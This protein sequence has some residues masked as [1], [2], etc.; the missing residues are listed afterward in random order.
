MY[1]LDSLTIG[2]YTVFHQCEVKW[3]GWGWGENGRGWGG[4]YDAVGNKFQAVALGV[5]VKI[6]LKLP[7][8]AQGLKICIHGQFHILNCFRRVAVIRNLLD[9]V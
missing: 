9:A 8:V 2:V 6:G 5:K 3:R 7:D 4:N 1:W